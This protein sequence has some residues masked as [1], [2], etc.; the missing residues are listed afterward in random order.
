M[1]F[2]HLSY[3]TVAAAIIGPIFLLLVMVY[4]FAPAQSAGNTDLHITA[5][6]EFYALHRYPAKRAHKAIAIGPG[7]YWGEASG[8]N[9]AKEAENAALSGCRNAL[10]TIGPKSLSRAECVLFDLDGN[11]TGKAP[12][13]GVPFGTTLT[14]PD[15]PLNEGYSF[16]PEGTPRGSVLFLHGCNGIKSINGWVYAWASFY[17]AAG[18][19]VFFPDSF[20]DQRDTELCGIPPPDQIDH[21]TR[22]M[23]L[24]IA[25]TKRSL[26]VLRKKYP[27]EPIYVHGHSEGGYAAQAL[28]ENVSGII[29]TGSPCGFGSAGTY[30][31][32]PKV[33]VL[34]IV[35]TKDSY[36]PDSSSPKR[37]ADYCKSVTGDGSLQF[38]SVKGLG[39]YAAPWWP[40][41]A[42]AIGKIID[43]DPPA[44]GRSPIDKTP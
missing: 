2:L 40:A 20:V 35:G 4:P 21:Q 34:V 13:I 25:Q 23:K 11:R 32:A 19:R 12:P 41:V 30:F 10:R 24:R 37:L 44:V 6:T 16:K 43:Y 33:P 31:S 27:G 29:V 36:V 38:I 39:H 26:S 5:T 1:M 28:G 22:N 3:R 17:R 9:S 42:N 7:G 14:E 15:R 18:Y 8:Q